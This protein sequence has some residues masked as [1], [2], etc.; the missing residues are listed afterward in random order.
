MLCSDTEFRQAIKDEE[1]IAAMEA[2]ADRPIAPADSTHQSYRDYTYQL[3]KLANILVE[4][5]SKILPSVSM[6]PI[7]RRWDSDKYQILR[8]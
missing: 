2:W 8:V 1:F 7:K 5:A 6:N 4:K 3:H